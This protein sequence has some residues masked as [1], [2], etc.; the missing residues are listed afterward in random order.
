MLIHEAGALPA[1]SQYRSRPG[2]SDS[3]GD[4]DAVAVICVINVLALSERRSQSRRTCELEIVSRTGTSVTVPP[5]NLLCYRQ[6]F[7]GRRRP[8][9]WDELRHHACTDPMSFIREGKS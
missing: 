9:V 8:C 3:I 2:S 7:S 1:Q 5:L 4:A 6:T